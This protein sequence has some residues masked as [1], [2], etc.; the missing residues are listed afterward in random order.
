MLGC[1]FLARGK[2]SSEVVNQLWLF[3]AYIRLPFNRTSGH[4]EEIDIWVEPIFCDLPH[5][6]EI[7]SSIEVAMPEMQD[8]AMNDPEPA[9]REGK[10][11][12]P[13]PCEVLDLPRIVFER[14]VD[15]KTVLAVDRM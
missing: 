11:S 5:P 15:T 13:P 7:V 12:V 1:V 8:L 6:P 14:I 3:F 10:E 4:D 2:V 9:L